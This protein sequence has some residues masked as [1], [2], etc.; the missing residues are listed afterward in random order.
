MFG[1]YMALHI[2]IATSSIGTLGS[3]AMEYSSFAVDGRPELSMIV[4]NPVTADDAARIR[5]LM[6]ALPD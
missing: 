4:Y 2:G 5:Q 1:P 6:A 3:L